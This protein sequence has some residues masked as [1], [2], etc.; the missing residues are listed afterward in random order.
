MK[1]EAERLTA[2]PPQAAKQALAATDTVFVIAGDLFIKEN[3]VA[4]CGPTHVADP[5]ELPS[6]NSYPKLRTVWKPGSGKGLEG[7][8]GAAIW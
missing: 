8:N 6:Q 3:R 1:E 5:Q 7:L 2:K 4:P